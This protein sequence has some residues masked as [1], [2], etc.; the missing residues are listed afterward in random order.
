[1]PSIQTAMPS[2]QNL[3]LMAQLSPATKPLAGM[4]A[5]L[6]LRQSP[7]P[8][9]HLSPSL[10]SLPFFPCICHCHAPHHSVDHS[11]LHLTSTSP[12]LLQNPHLP[13]LSS[14]LAKPPTSP[15][16]PPLLQPF[17]LQYAIAMLPIT[18]WITVFLSR[19]NM[20]I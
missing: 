15:T 14:S 17:P 5:S 12:P 11:L 1:M 13:S 19:L 4:L 7:P 6:M 8:N 18:V 16:S 9:F 2:A 10:A 3:V 20:A